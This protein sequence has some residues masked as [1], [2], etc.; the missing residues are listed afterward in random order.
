MSK[1]ESFA[2]IAVMEQFCKEQ[3]F[4]GGCNYEVGKM[5]YCGSRIMQQT[6]PGDILILICKAFTLQ[7]I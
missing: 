6:K 2:M 4:H 1:K 3:L 7:L 5:L